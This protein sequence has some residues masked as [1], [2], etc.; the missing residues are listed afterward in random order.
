MS[1][2]ILEEQ[3]RALPD[4]CVEEVSRYIEFVMYLR[5]K[6]S[7]EQSEYDISSFF[8]SVSSLPDGMELQREARDEWV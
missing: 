8:G 5:K 7:E 6:V 1:H 2:A 3:V 4:E